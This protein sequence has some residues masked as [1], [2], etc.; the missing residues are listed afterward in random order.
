MTASASGTGRAPVACRGVFA[1]RA[2]PSAAAAGEALARRMRAFRTLVDLHG[3]PPRIRAQAGCSAM[4]E[5]QL[6]RGRTVQPLAAAWSA[7]EPRHAARLDR[8]ARLW[9][10]CRP[11]PCTGPDLRIHRWPRANPRRIVLRASLVVVVCA[12]DRSRQRAADYTVDAFRWVADSHEVRDV[13]EVDIRESREQ[14]MT[15]LFEPEHNLEERIL[16]EQFEL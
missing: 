12:A 8:F 15:L 13:V 5:P 10:N 3:T 6:S 11:R 16:D 14:T 2:A 1:M 9:E 7:A 4:A